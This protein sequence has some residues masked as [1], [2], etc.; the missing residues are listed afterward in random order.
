[1]KTVYVIPLVI[2][3]AGASA[4]AQLQK[5]TIELTPTPASVTVAAG[6]KGRV[7]LKVK[8]PQD[9]HVQSDKPDDPG[10]IATV[11]TITPVPGV[12]V[13]RIVYPAAA[14]FQQ[15][16]RAK[17][18][19]VFGPELVID[20]QLSIAPDITAAALKIPAQ[21]RYQACNERVCFAP[22]RASAEW[23]VNVDAR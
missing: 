1:M 8:L 23:V 22:A 3:C 9:V 10:L 20:V 15:A 17:P 12:S 21:L 18:L 5:P 19:A 13:D 4:G 2:A 11:L 14:P 7:S 16:G 6:G